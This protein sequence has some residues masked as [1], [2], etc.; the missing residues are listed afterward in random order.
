MKKHLFSRIVPSTGSC[1]SITVRALLWCFVLWT[2]CSASYGAV[3]TVPGDYST[4]QAAIDASVD[5]DEI[6]VSPGGYIENINFGGKNIVL[7]STDPTD[8]D[9]VANTG[10][11]TLLNGSVVTFAGTETSDCVLS[12]FLLQLGRAPNGGGI[13]G[14]GTLA[15]IRN[16]NIRDNDATNGG[17]GLYRCDGTIQ[18]N[19][20]LYNS[21]DWGGGLYGCN[22]TIE[23]NSIRRNSADYGGGLYACNGTIR[24]SIISQSRGS[25]LYECHGTIENNVIRHN[26]TGTMSP[27]TRNRPGSGL[28][29]CNGSIRNNTIVGNWTKYNGGGLYDCSGTLVNCIIWGNSADGD[30]DQVYDCSTPLYSCIQGWTAGGTGNISANPRFDTGG[31][32]RLLPDSPCIDAGSYIVDLIE[33]F[34]GE[35]RGWDASPEPRG[36]GSDYDIGADEHIPDT[37]GDGLLDHIETC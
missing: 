26:H 35:P 36:D 17:G 14:N 25:G 7:R 2:L 4:I 27:S 23:N 19:I 29:R 18:D 34:E 3:I 6:I 13:C 30:G 10:I 33:D 31:D 22:G 12:G 15:T 5:G 16:N 24:N 9:V 20:I 1:F 21:A 11:T 32:Y 8:P 28:Y 37:D